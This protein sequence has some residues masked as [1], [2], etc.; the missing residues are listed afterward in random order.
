M[1]KNKFLLKIIRYFSII[2]A[3]FI[4]TICF[5]YL[6]FINSNIITN[7]DY[8]L[9]INPFDNFYSLSNKL[10]IKKFYLRIF[11]KLNKPNFVLQVWEYKITKNSNISNIIKQLQNPINKDESLTILEWWNIFDIDDLLTNKWLIK[12]WDLKNNYQN[13]EWFLYPDTYNYNPSN[14]VLNNFVNKMINNFELLVKN[15]ILYKLNDKEIYNLL[16]LSSIVEKEANIKDNPNEISIIAWILK[17][18]LKEN[19]YIWADITVCYNYKLTSH[20]CDTKF[21]TSHIYDKND[22]NTR[23][24]YWLPK[25]PI[26]NPSYKTISNTLNH[27]NSPYYYYLHDNNWKIHYAK[28]IEEHNSNKNRYLK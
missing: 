7:Q 9:K 20:E 14:F 10:N 8:I 12:K 2:V 1:E 3:I 16:I 5:N 18:R 22:Y 4:A 25:T 15:K 23:T 11:L 24:M 28:N 19:W 27:K 13:Y 17:K 26:W 21:I 6:N